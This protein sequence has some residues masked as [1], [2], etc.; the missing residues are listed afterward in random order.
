M[1]SNTGKQKKHK[2]KFQY[3]SPNGARIHRKSSIETS[4]IRGVFNSEGEKV[5][6]ELTVE[7]QNFLDNYYKEF[8]HGTFNTD[9]ESIKLFK[10]AK[11]LSKEPRN[12]KFY[13]ENGFFPEDVEKAI[14]DFNNKSKSLGNLAYNFWDQREINSDDYKRRYDIQNNSCRGLQL[15]SFED[16]QYVY[17]QDDDSS[18][19]IIEDLIT[20]SEE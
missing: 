19:T 15:D 9:K 14:S 13:K 5:I 3:L 4:Y 20:E 11:R 17:L 7:E 2:K 10:I 12:V 16:L 6:R 18:N 1:T 8:V